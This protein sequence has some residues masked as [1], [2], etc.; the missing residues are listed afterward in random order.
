MVAGPLPLKKGLHASLMEWHVGTLLFM[1]AA[2]ALAMETGAAKEAPFYLAVSVLLL[3][4]VVM[5]PMKKELHVSLTQEGRV[6][7]LFSRMG[8]GVLPI[9]Q[10]HVILVR[11]MALRF[12]FSVKSFS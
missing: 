12:S 1:K 3:Q 2:P 6:D 5:L 7:F 8:V 9:H 11:S 4:V 10:I